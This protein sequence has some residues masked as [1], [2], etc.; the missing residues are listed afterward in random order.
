MTRSQAE[1]NRLPETERQ[2]LVAELMR[3]RRLRREAAPTLSHG[4]R[5]LWFLHRLAP[6][7]SAFHVVFAARVVSPI[8]TDALESAFQRLAERHDALRAV[9]VTRQGR[10]VQE[11]REEVR[12]PFQRV[13][14][15]D[16]SL[17]RVH[18]ALG[19]EVRRPFDLAE[20]V[21]R[22]CVYSRTSTESFLAATF[23]HI[24]M[25]GWSLWMCLEELGELYRAACRRL[26]S[27]QLPPSRPF[28]DC[29]DGESRAVS[30][31][32]G[33]ES[34]RYWRRRIDRVS[35]VLDIPTDKAR[36]PV[37][38]FRGASHTFR[39]GT[40]D[41][42]ALARLVGASRATVSMGVLSLFSTLLYRYTA[43]R[44]FVVGY[45]TSGRSH[46]E[47]ET[48]VGYLANPLPFRV[49]VDPTDTF[50]EVLL[51][52]RNS[53]L[54][55]L[56]HQDYPFSLLVDEVSPTRDT[57]RSPLVQV[58][59]VCEKPQLFGSEQ[60]AGFIL[61]EPGASLDIGDLRC[62]SLALPAQTEGQFDLTLVLV[63]GEDGLAMLL[64]YNADLFE[65]STIVRFAGHL[66][67][68]TRHA[69][70]QPDTPISQLS[71]R[72]P[73]ER[74][75]TESV[76]SLTADR[77]CLHD[78]FEANAERTP[79]APAAV[80]E[81]RQLTYG[82]LR[83]RSDRLAWVLRGRG[84]GPDVMVGL[85]VER[86]LD[87]VVATLAI[88]K[89]GGA[90][91]PLDPRYP[92][93]R[94]DFMLTDAQVPLLVTQ[95]SLVGAVDPGGADMVLVDDEAS[96]AAAPAAVL[97]RA[98]VDGTNLAYVIY[99][100]GSTGRPKGVQLVQRG[101]T[102]VAREQ[103]RLFGVGPG[104]RV[105]QFASL[106]FDAA[107]F[108]L[109]M[110]FGSGAT[111]HLAPPESLLPGLP[112]L[113]TLKR[114][115]ITVV[116]LPPSAL[117]NLP[118]EALP[119]LRT[120]TVAG[121][122]CPAELVSRWSAGR[123]FFN[124]YGPTEATI[125]ATAARCTDGGRA[126]SIGRAISHTSTYVLDEQRQPVPIGVPGELHLGGVG[127]AR[128]YLNRPELTTERFID[129]P[130][131]SGTDRLYRTGDLVRQREDGEIEYLGRTDSQ[132]KVRGYRVEPGE[133]EVVL[134]RHPGVHE[135]AVQLHG[136]EPDAQELVAYLTRT[137]GA[138]VSE[139]ELRKNLQRQLPDFMVP[140]IF[141]VLDRMPLT[142]SG[143]VDRQALSPPERTINLAGETSPP[144]GRLQQLV[145]S[146]WR[147]VLHLD[148]V[149]ADDNFFELGGNSL[150]LA[151]VHAELTGLLARDISVVDMFRYPTLRDLAAYLGDEKADDEDRA[152]DAVVGGRNRLRAQ[153]QR[154]RADENGP[155]GRRR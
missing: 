50:R 18:R 26:P 99:T 57:S 134:G 31:S 41:T 66:C 143:K 110:A 6:Q 15:A 63:E 118:V 139:P 70:R 51:R 48:V 37:Q 153:A 145:A 128:G 27:P 4:Q 21:M 148:D 52:V 123:A 36:P 101:L 146:V 151:K 38:T 77:T 39:L 122:R 154:R 137:P 81:G 33:A 56:E 10:P 138:R 46:A 115:R 12:V 14:A 106:S 8:D 130:F 32:A 67:A 53:L 108:E 22:V 121:E 28:A 2:R 102:N 89:A 35:T 40:A 132:V 5:A 155:A 72:T 120:V 112:L 87:L 114:H 44:D 116:T 54:D 94:L 93:E 91:L 69:V 73:D 49:T 23:H 131:G 103:Q 83:E 141:V 126:P 136:D 58:M 17:A 60:T 45:L 133:I 152:E 59:F 71:V 144:R 119:D 113:E 25:D 140:G 105:L 125:W 1:F 42:A 142:A 80:Y 82:A 7:S 98:D 13:D 150:L 135:V 75:H 19:D 62:E 24:A 109:A 11:F 74:R 104:A 79:E 29:V 84:V 78:L 88:L 92:R 86:S 64:D 111:L 147:E 20:G 61:G 149:S 3:V 9:F 97:P 95:R 129:S 16:W 65:R 76:L 85:C 90:F 43:Q 100:S 96:W 47:H 68:L 55:D 124:L 127:V 30:S 117:L 34:R 107:V